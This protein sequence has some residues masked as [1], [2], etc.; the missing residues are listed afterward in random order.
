MT[1]ASARFRAIGT[2]VGV[3]CTQAGE[4]ARAVALLRARLAELDRAA[5]RFRD[6]S[7]LAAL[8]RRSAESAATD[9]TA[10]L[11]VPVDGTLAACLRAAMRTERLTAGL[12][13]ASLGTALIAC[14]Y[15]DD[16]DRVRARGHGTADRSRHGASVPLARVSFDERTGELTMPAGAALDL[17]ASAKAWAADAIA[18]ELAAGGAGGFLVDLG[19]DIAVAGAPPPHGWA[20]G[21][22]EWDGTV[23]QVVRSTGQAFATSSTRLRTWTHHGVARHHIIDPRTGEPARTRWAQVTCAGPDAVQANAASTAAIILDDHAVRWL[24]DRGVPARLVT[25]DRR[26]ETTPG[27]PAV[28]AGERRAS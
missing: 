3:V 25:A 1:G 10:R 6:D 5:S 19:G 7:E 24:T 8:N 27:W 16:L 13:C 17:G 22:R 23:A 21:V 4:R 15:D 28:A 14:G 9:P 12:V 20:V 18:A 26:V 2:T 11:R